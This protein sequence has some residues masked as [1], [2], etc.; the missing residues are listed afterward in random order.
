MKLIRYA[1]AM[2]SLV[3]AV[4]GQSPPA[5]ATPPSQQIS[6]QAAY[7]QASR[8]LQITRNSMA[9]WSGTELEALSVA[10]KN[11]AAACTSRPAN[12][13]SGDDLIALAKLCSFGQKWPSAGSAALAYIDSNDPVK[14]QLGL[15]YAYNLGAAL[16][17][18]D[19]AAIS[20]AAKTMLGAVPYDA[21]SDATT[22]DALRYLQLAY[23]DDALE[24]FALREPMILTALKTEKPLLPRHVLYADG[25]AMAAIQQYAGKTEDAETT[26]AAL[27]QALGAVESLAADDALP[28]VDSRR[29]YA[30]LG[31][32]LPKLPL[33][34]SLADPKEPPQ[35][36]LSGGSSTALFLFPEWCAQCTRMVG[37][38][39]GA[40]PHFDQS[41]TRI[42]ALLAGP[43]PDRASLQPAK[44]RSAAKPGD[45]KGE[46]KTT[47]Q[48]LLHTPTLIVGTEALSTFGATDF[49]F[50]IL[51]DH[52]GI[53]RFMGPA[54][55]TALQPGDFLDQVTAHVAE[56]WPT[57]KLP[58]EAS[59]GQ[60]KQ[61]S[62]VR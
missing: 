52:T 54:P 27:D 17:T 50:F 36:S 15:A 25:L 39:A 13:Y 16:Q 20:I 9:N 32:P 60:R 51:V 46:P 10:Q 38:I 58:V 3:S 40:A 1:A 42:V 56:L 4:E 11:A 53:V 6:P 21:V 61:S 23:T 49:P 24:L 14:P 22:N 7:D 59:L 5:P 43:A 44:P 2:F 37:A 19:V 55:E 47:A 26:V 35:L 8:P 28:I 33:Q 30:L 31:Q 45:E 48:L 57:Q 18:H 12:A 62:E 34:L 29:Q 41:H